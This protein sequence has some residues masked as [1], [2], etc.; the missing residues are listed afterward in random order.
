VVALDIDRDFVWKRLI[1][2]ARDSPGTLI[3]PMK[4]K[5]PEN[6]TDDEIAAQAGCDLMAQ[7]PEVCNWVESLAGQYKNMVVGTYVYLDGEAH[8]RVALAADAVAR[9]MTEKFQ[10]PIAYLCTPTDLHVVPEGANKAAK[11]NFN[12]ISAANLVL[13]LLSLLSFG[14]VLN[15]N[16]PSTKD[17]KGESFF[18]VD[19]LVV[20]QG[21]N[22]ALA[23]RMQ[24]WRVIV[25]RNGGSVTS[26]HIAPATATRSVISNKTFAWAYDGMPFIKPYEI[27]EEGTSN[28]VMAA[29]LIND[30]QNKTPAHPSQALR[31]PYQLFSY[32]GFHGG[33]WRAGYKYES[34]GA[35]AVLIHFVKVGRPVIA[36]LVAALIYFFFR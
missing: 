27:F 8:I 26:S 6:A 4:T 14:K 32:N 11:A 30:L 21:P 2:I 35:V 12:S 16:F 15:K 33:T 9:R 24:H 10:T 25:A 5:V 28:A 1:K 13:R 18:Y 23:K 20:P 31:N 34:I 3:F 17:A 19:G 22:Y 36:A 29:L 7:T